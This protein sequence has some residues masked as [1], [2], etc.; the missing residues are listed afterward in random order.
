MPPVL[1]LQRDNVITIVRDWTYSLAPTIYYNRSLL[2]VEEYKL[3][4][5][6]NNGTIAYY[7]YVVDNYGY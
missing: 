2:S 4:R 1:I 3:D 7:N 6:E 5:I